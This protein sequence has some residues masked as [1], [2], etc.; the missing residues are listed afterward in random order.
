MEGTRSE[1]GSFLFRKSYGSEF[2]FGIVLLVTMFVVYLCMESLYLAYKRW[3]L[4]KVELYPYT[5]TSNKT[6]IIPQNPADIKAKPAL[7]SENESTGIEFTYTVFL[8]INDSTFT[9]DATTRYMKSIFHKGYKTP[10]PLCGPG[11]F[12]LSSENTL[13]IVMN[14]YETWYNKV[15]IPNIPVEKWF[16]LSLVCRNNTLEVYLNGNL[17]KKL[18]FDGSVPYQNYQDIVIFS[19][20]IMNANEYTALTET[21]KGIPV[22][23]SFVVNG[24][25]NGSLSVLTYYRYALSFSEIQ[26]SMNEGPSSRVES[27]NMD[28]PPYLI[29]SWWTQPIKNT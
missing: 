12:A 24:H 22:G 18:A 21:T 25:M 6:I 15:D 23:D 29:D 7:L 9:G 2:L 11:V 17:A 19:G 16:H 8:Y 27:G 3:S 10:F 26:K 14:S 1:S 20:A 28:R 4:S 5:V 13:R